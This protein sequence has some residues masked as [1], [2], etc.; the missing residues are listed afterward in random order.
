MVVLQKEDEETINSIKDFND[1]QIITQKKRDMEVPLRRDLKMSKLN[2]FV[3][4]MLM[5]QWIPNIL[6]RC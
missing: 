1:I 2:S 3:L 4:S 5:D 6:I